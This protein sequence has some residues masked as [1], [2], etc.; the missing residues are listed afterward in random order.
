MNTR[1]R[2]QSAVEFALTH[3]R[4]MDIITG[5]KVAVAD[6]LKSLDPQVDV[7]STDYFNHSFIPDLVVKWHEAGRVAERNV[8]LRYTL[9]S[10]SIGGDVSAL[11]DLGPIFLTLKTNEDSS[12]REDVKQ[13]V[14]GTDRVL[15]T[16][17]A[18]LDE[19]VAVEPSNT[20]SPLLSLARGNIVR[21]GRGLLET[22][23]VNELIAASAPDADGVLQEAD[24]E[25]FVSLIRDL[26]VS[27][28]A[29]RLRRA[30]DLIQLG[31]SSDFEGLLGD[32]PS[33]LIRGVL[34]DVELRVLLPYLLSRPEITRSSR[35]WSYVGSM[36][37]LK[38]LEEASSE[39]QGFDLTP[40]I[41]ANISTWF[42]S[43]GS[44]VLRDG[45]L[46]DSSMI[47][48]SAEG[49]GVVEESAIAG[50]ADETAYGLAGEESPAGWRVHSG[51]LSLNLGRWRLLVASSGSKL[52][53]RIGSLSA[54]WADLRPALEDFE[55]ARVTLLG[56]ARRVEVAA[57]RDADVRADVARIS[58][59]L[60]DSFYV[61]SAAV[62]GQGETG[63]AV[64]EVDFTRMLT[65]SA[66]RERISI[67]GIARIALRLL[68]YRNPVD[69]DDMAR[70]LDVA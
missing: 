49:S 62:W 16:D 4:E 40:L 57:E 10:A 45:D 61:P 44:L 34:S 24:L 52:R 56:L 46:T 36:M 60:D 11:A 28:A 6:E 65:F 15:V 23:T 12:T 38:S 32:D 54:R 63:R 13:Q 35:Y 1:A 70:Y 58:D 53:G 3:E 22:T 39:L 26:F 19:A 31:V 5:V 67:G 27:D 25:R 8:Y 2:A 64:V 41:S 17:V 47:D 43:R 30:S 48:G 20:I 21:G 51:I 59:S 29:T 69:R 55:L 33:R 9:R 18:A 7:R 66:S 14:S 68:G 42:A 50:S 37:D